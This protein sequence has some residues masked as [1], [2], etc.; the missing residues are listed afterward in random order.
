MS[1]PNKT[2]H[3]KKIWNKMVYDWNDLAKTLTK[4][5]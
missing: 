3:L 4:M 1:N 2:R 5:F